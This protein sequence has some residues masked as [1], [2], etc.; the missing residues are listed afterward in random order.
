MVYSCSGHATT[1]PLRRRLERTDGKLFDAYDASIN[2]LAH[3]DGGHL[4]VDDARSSN[5]NVT[6]SFRK[7][8]GPVASGWPPLA[9]HARTVREGDVDVDRVP[10][11][12]SRSQTGGG[13]AGVG[14]EFTGE[15]GADSHSQFGRGARSRVVMVVCGHLP[16]V[17]APGHLLRLAPAGDHHRG[18]RVLRQ[19]HQLPD[20]TNK[21]HL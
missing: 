21:P 9:P 11:V 20:G 7:R 5:A 3:V 19:H 6:K 14:S 10:A 13:F 4:R 17:H 2:P 16:G 12:G 18:G 8:V 1:D 15:R